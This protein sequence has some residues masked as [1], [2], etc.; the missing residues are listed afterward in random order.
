[1]GA[2]CTKP[3]T[4][5]A[6][7]AARRPSLAASDATHRRVRLEISIVKPPTDGADAWSGMAVA[8]LGIELAEMQDFTFIKTLQRSGLCEKAGL[9]V[10]DR[11]VSV[12]GVAVDHI[13][14]SSKVLQSIA[15]AQEGS[16]CVVAVDRAVARIPSSVVTQPG[17]KAFHAKVFNSL[18]GEFRLDVGSAEV[19]E[20]FVGVFWSAFPTSESPE[21]YRFPILS[22]DPRS[23]LA[24]A[25]L[26]AGDV[27]LEMGSFG[28][29]SKHV[30]ANKSE[31]ETLLE[32][33]RTGHASHC[34]LNL[35]V[36]RPPEEEESGRASEALNAVSPTEV[37]C[38]PAAPAATAAAPS[39]AAAA[40]SSA[41]AAAAK[42]PQTLPNAT[43][44]VTY[45]AAQ[46]EELIQQ[47]QQVGFG[48]L[49]GYSVADVAEYRLS[50]RSNKS[51]PSGEGVQNS[52]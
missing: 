29:T 43:N 40:P 12:D 42:N 31:V 18:P 38:E 17:A 19:A 9:L 36:L 14:T 48:A 46:T 41:A 1:M 25:G 33:L 23:K 11:I 28:M 13:F 35:L 45:R 26:R 39:S 8:R 2:C 50:S 16:A 24:M 5:D 32:R 21:G 49:P 4:F 51:T 34:S 20:T 3:E 47:Q 27:L 22:L 15:Q 7:D 10:G 37:R 30:P 52:V 6:V 44:V